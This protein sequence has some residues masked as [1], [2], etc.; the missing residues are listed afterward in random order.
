LRD[1]PA[2]TPDGTR[3]RLS[4]NVALVS[5]SPPRRTATPRVSASIEPS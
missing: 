1:Q 5:T 2:E 4:S 3:L